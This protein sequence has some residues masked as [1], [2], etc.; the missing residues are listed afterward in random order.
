MRRWRGTVAG[1]TISIMRGGDP[2]SRLSVWVF[3]SRYSWFSFSVHACTMYRCLWFFFFLFFS[4]RSIGSF[5][6]VASLVSSSSPFHILALIILMLLLIRILPFHLHISLFPII[7]SAHRQ[8][9]VRTLI[10]THIGGSTNS[11]GPISSRIHLIFPPTPHVSVGSLP[12]SSRTHTVIRLSLIRIVH[13]L[14]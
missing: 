11:L 10:A 1:R 4:L 13:P 5:T 12:F 14:A 2:A 7:T 9:L 8:H 6:L 3:F